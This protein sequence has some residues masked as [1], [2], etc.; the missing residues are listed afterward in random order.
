MSHLNPRDYYRPTMLQRATP[1]VVRYIEAL[2]DY[3]E[4]L[5]ASLK[6]IK[7]QMEETHGE[8]AKFHFPYG[9]VCEAIEHKDVK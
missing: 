8:N 7:L 9:I 6:L 3:S 2:E 5:E 4:S 1:G